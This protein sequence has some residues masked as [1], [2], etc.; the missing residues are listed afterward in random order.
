MKGWH[1]MGWILV[2]LGLW[3]TAFAL[4]AIILREL[5]VTT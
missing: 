4:F 2:G 1:W 5:G 3:V